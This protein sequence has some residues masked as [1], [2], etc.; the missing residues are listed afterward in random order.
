MPDLAL[1]ADAYGTKLIAKWPGHQ[2]GGQLIIDTFTE[3]FSG[4]HAEYE[5]EQ[6]AKLGKSLC[7]D[8]SLPEH[9]LSD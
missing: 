5:E 2:D 6:L 1:V 9:Q 4:D 3:V 7:S 8:L